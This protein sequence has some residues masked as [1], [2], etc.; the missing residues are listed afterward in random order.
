VFSV[1]VCVLCV[2]CVSLC[3]C[4]CF[5]FSVRVCVLS[6]FV[7]G[8]CLC[9]FVCLCVCVYYFTKVNIRSTGPTLTRFVVSIAPLKYLYCSKSGSLML[10]NPLKTK[11]H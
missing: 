4:V 7:F 2:W 8:V 3:F 10:L 11:R 1:R 6:V 9:L 5:V